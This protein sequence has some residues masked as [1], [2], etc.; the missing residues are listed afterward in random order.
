MS[1]PLQLWEPVL[2]LGG[3]AFMIYFEIELGKFFFAK[4]PGWRRR[5]HAT[6][7]YKWLDAHEPGVRINCRDGSSLAVGWFRQ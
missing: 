5:F 1:P 6:R 7:L 4:A 2:A 3:A